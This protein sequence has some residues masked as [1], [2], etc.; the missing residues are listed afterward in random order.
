MKHLLI[1]SYYFP[2]VGQSGVQ[3]VLK[4]VKYLP[5]YGWQPVVITPAHGGSGV[6]DTELLADAGSTPVIRTCSLDPLF[7]TPRRA[8]ARSPQRGGLVAALSRWAIPDNKLGWIP[9]ALRAGRS[10]AARYPI[11]AILS[12]APPYSSHL[13]GLRLRRALGKPLVSDFRDSWTRYTWVSYP[14][15]LHRRLDRWLESRVVAGSDLVLGVNQQIVNELRADHPAHA[16]RC[17]LLSHG[18]DPGDFRDP[19][20]SDR[21]HFIIAHT[22][23]L[24]NDRSPRPL[25][26]AL[27]IIKARN[28]AMS[29]RIRVVFA[30]QC[31]PA[32]EA[33]A[34]NAGLADIV[35]FS[36]YLP[37]SR[38][39][40]LLQRAACLWLVMGPEETANVTPGKLFEYLGA[41]RPILAT[42][43][44]Q[45]QAAAIIRE[46]AAGQVFAPAAPDQ[47]ATAIEALVERWAR[48]EQLYQG[49]A[50]AVARYDR[51]E[52]ARQLAVMLDGLA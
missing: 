14:M 38:S 8:A 34:A 19:V 33:L 23:T 45:G 49:N 3:R 47:L 31:R 43:P 44:Q 48:G 17:R 16:G 13:A 30:G 5:Q 10:A 28:P 2:P 50:A 27:R 25:L 36:G 9:F 29:A 46:T 6:Y 42:A 32:D 37:H 40:L 7:L 41:R 18:F 20:P 15:P 24:I 11:A 51:R 1:L 22:G 21:E 39:V 4:L 35:T 26:N 12:S 52:I